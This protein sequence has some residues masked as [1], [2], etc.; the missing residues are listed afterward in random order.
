M[1]GG[2]LLFR[3]LMHTHEQEHASMKPDESAPQNYTAAQKAIL[4]SLGLSED[5]GWEFHGDDRRPTMPSTWQEF[6]KRSYEA[7]RKREA[8][9]DTEFLKQCGIK[10]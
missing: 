2:L 3:L 8:E 9:A 5:E 1:Q 6:C 10:L 4:L 7:R